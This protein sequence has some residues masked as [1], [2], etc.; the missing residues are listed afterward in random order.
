MWT[1]SGGWP[2]KSWAAGP[3]LPLH[4]A[5]AAVDAV[6]SSGTTTAIAITVA[7]SVLVAL[8]GAFSQR[9]RRKE[10]EPPAPPLDPSASQDNLGTHGFRLDQHDE[11]LQH[12]VERAGQHDVQ[13]ALYDRQFAE[14]A[15]RMAALEQH[16][17][18]PPQEQG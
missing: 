12:L 16:R 3:L 8:I 11:Q 7:G 6:T 2:A 18:T 15:D 9:G 1:A 4:I 17:R 10:T 5:E 13:Q 14:L